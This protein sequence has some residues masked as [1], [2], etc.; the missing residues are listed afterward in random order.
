MSILGAALRKEVDGQAALTATFDIGGE[1]HKVGSKPI[2]PADF[3]VINK[4]RNVPFQQ[5]P[6]QF[7]GQ[8]LLLIRKT[9]LCDD[10]GVISDD[11][12]FDMKDKPVLMRL[13]V[14]K[15]ST[16]FTD[17]FGSQFDTDEDEI[18]DDGEVK[19]TTKKKT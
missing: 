3:E 19:G 8:V 9:R 15:V 7:D 14:E 4:G 2:T 17:L 6:T 13:P 11:K 10:E 1:K 16:M 12:V 5:D 18:T